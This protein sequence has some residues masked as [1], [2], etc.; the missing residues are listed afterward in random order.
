MA[1]N[2]EVTCPCC[3]SLIVIDRISGEVLMHTPRKSAGPPSLEA[4]VSQLASSKSE[5][6]KKFERNLESQKDRGRILE[7]KFKE[8]M[9]RADKSDKP[10]VN[11]MDLD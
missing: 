9:Q 6:A 1:E 8:A 4:M 11:P 2:F 3:E 5:M 7:E 10:F